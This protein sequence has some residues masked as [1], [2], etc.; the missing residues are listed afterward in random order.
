MMSSSI[1]DSIAAP[2]LPRE[3]PGLVWNREELGT[4]RARGLLHPIGSAV[5]DPIP[6]N[7]PI[8]LEAGAFV[9][10]GEPIG[11]GRQGVVYSIATCDRACIKICRNEV[12]S[13]Q[14][15]RELL[16]IPR[17]NE[18]G[19]AFPSVLAAD[20]F[21]RWIVKERWRGVQSGN[22]LL[23][24]N[25]R[26]LPPWA[27]R[28]LYE[29]VEKFEKSGLCAAWMPSN[30]V[31]GQRKCA[32]FET[33]FWPTDS[34]DWTFR[35]CFLPVWLPHGIPESCLEGFPPYKWRATGIEDARR[36]W[37]SDEAYEPWREMFG[38]FPELSSD[39]WTS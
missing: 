32:T 34:Y 14:F 31:F 19:I 6:P 27:V 23:A 7:T 10:L 37:E 28:S 8:E 35:T 11:E 24:A 21:G 5:I 2:P 38:D 4:L 25:E 15:R 1:P 18:L 3:I 22:T 20:R 33:A 39:W 17:F 9:V 30:V 16:G 26:R 13:K 36:A 12:A 29:Y